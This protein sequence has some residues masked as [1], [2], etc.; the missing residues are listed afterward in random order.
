MLI[1]AHL[2]LRGSE[3]QLSD[4]AWATTC[5]SGSQFSIV[6][7][8]SRSTRWSWTRRRRI[9][10]TLAGLAPVRPE[11]ERFGSVIGPPPQAAEYWNNQQG[12]SRLEFLPRI[13]LNRTADPGAVSYGRCWHEQGERSTQADTRTGICAAVLVRLHPERVR[14]GVWPYTSLP[15]RGR[16]S[17]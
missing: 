8:G 1:D 12:G 17:R 2:M 3:L 6:A 14:T 5:R 7:K 9:A 13:S 11:D 10:S 4:P 15:R 16:P